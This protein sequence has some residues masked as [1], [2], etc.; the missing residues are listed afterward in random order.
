MNDGKAQLEEAENTLAA[1]WQEYYS[2]K[3]KLDDG[4]AQLAQA[5]KNWKKGRPRLK[6]PK[7]TG[8]RPGPD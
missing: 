5:K 8:S 2:G 7:G 4:K 3:E 6:T 1:K